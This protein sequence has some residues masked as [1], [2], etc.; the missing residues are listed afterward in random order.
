V[1]FQDFIR[2]IAMKTTIPCENCGKKITIE[3]ST[4]P[5]LN[6]IAQRANKSDTRE[7]YVDCPHC[8]GETVAQVPTERK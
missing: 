7:V 3:T 5:K 1:G 6:P 8:G 4:L 2:M